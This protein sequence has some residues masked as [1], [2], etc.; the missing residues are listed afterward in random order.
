MTEDSRYTSEQ[1]ADAP[2]LGA[3]VD[4]EL[5]RECNC[6]RCAELWDAMTAWADGQDGAGD[7]T[8]DANGQE[9]WGEP[10]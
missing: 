1:L 4:P 6:E 7:A 3:G 10:A 5:V 2:M 9:Q 8:L